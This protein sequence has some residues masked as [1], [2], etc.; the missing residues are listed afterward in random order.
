MNLLVCRTCDAPA[1]RLVIEHPTHLF[2]EAINRFAIDNPGLDTADWCGHL[3]AHI[4][5]LAG[6]R[7]LVHAD[8]DPYAGQWRT[9]DTDVDGP[10]REYL[11]HAEPDDPDFAVLDIDGHR[12]THMI[13]R[14]AT[15]IGVTDPFL[16]RA[17][18]NNDLTAYQLFNVMC[19]FPP[20][21]DAPVWVGAC[22]AHA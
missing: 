6:G 20:A 12:V 1:A 21:G 16:A 4:A 8:G 18:F 9:P 22:T 3:A 5:T 13:D 2:R 10:P 7:W 19:E 17:L 14:A 11:L 15:R